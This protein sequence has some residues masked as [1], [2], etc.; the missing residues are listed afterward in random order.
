LKTAGESSE[1]MHSQKELKG[2]LFLGFELTDTN[3]GGL[4]Q[5]YRKLLAFLLWAT[6]LRTLSP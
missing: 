1:C 3:P 6:F 5:S 4:C 2:I